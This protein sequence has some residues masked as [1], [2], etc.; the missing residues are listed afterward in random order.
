M[1]FIDAGKSD[2]AVIADVRKLNDQRK[3]DSKGQEIAGLMQQRITL[4]A[5]ILNPAMT[6]EELAQLT[7]KDQLLMIMEEVKKRGLLPYIIKVGLL[8]SDLS[9]FAP[10]NAEY[11]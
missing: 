1:D 2:P 8:V 5:S 3:V 9:Q 6:K 4:S 11:V 7:Q 10:L